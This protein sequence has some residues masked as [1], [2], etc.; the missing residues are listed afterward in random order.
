[1]QNSTEELI[2]YYSKDYSG[3]YKEGDVAF[4]W[5]AGNLFLN[6]IY[7]P[8]QTISEKDL[9]ERVSD[10]ETPKITREDDPEVGQCVFDTTLGKPI[11]CKRRKILGTAAVWVDATGATV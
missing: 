5:R 11:W 1:M 3:E 6:K 9:F 4:Y 10:L 8:T 2:Q 7:K